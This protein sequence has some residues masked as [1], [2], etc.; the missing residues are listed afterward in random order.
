MNEI[1]AKGIESFQSTFFIYLLFVVVGLYFSTLFYSKMQKLKLKLKFLTNNDALTQLANRNAYKSKIDTLL[2]DKTIN[3]L[4]LLFMGLD[5]FKTINDSLGH[6]TGDLLLQAVAQRIKSKIDG[7]EILS[8]FGGDEFVVLFSNVKEKKT[9]ED[10]ASRIHKIFNEA[11]LLDGYE[12]YTTLS[13]GVSSYPE[14]ASDTES[15]V[16]NADIAMYAAKHTGK[17][18]SSFYNTFM[19]QESKLKF[20]LDFELHKALENNEFYLLFQPQISLKDEK[21]IGVEALLRW[22]N[23][24][25]GLV[26]PV[27]FIPIAENNGLIVPI[28][29]WVIDTSC[30]QVKE[31]ENTLMQDITIS[32]NI[33]VKQLLHQDLYTYIKKAVL[34]NDI[35]AKL[36]ELEITESVI[37]ENVDEV[38][39]TLVKLK[40]LGLSI[41]IDD[42]GTGYSSLSYLKKLPIDKLKVDRAFIKDIPSDTDDMAIT[43]AI[44]TLAK[45]LNLKIVAE[46]PETAEQINFLK[47]TCCDIA[48][49]YFYSEPITPKECGALTLRL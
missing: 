8:R 4:Y 5:N 44:I 16:K 22:N 14:D 34:E 47:G 42:F 27:D 1:Y 9:M 46:G 32:I 48:Q 29:E 33:S 20:S 7:F 25:L 24:L 40:K 31:W 45:S 3:N 28:G 12:V 49:G 10:I 39:G 41:A 43:Q 21:I 35:D 2:E 19:Y 11:F 13:I 36:L 23:Q 38:I 6:T 15:L 26:S 30:K 17:G 18:Q 37:M